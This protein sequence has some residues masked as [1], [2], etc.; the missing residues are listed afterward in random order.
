MKTV[1]PN[2]TR[3]KLNIFRRYK[4]KNDAAMKLYLRHTD[5]NWRRA[6]YWYRVAGKW[7]KRA[8]QQF[9]EFCA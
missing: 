3:R 4:A 5:N 1:N 8:R 9:P 7:A 2:K 6:D